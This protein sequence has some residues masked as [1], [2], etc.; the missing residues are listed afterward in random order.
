LRFLIILFLAAPLT[1]CAQINVNHF[2][3]NG[4]QAIMNNEYPRAIE[5]FNQVVSVRPDLFE[6]Y[7]LRAISKYNLGDYKGAEQDL[8]AAIQMKPNYPEALLYRGICRERMMNFSDAIS[9]FDRALKLEPYNAEI[10][11]R[12]AFTKSMMEEHSAA[13]EVCNQA[14]KIDKRNERAY[15]CRAWNRFKIYDVEGA[16]QDY[17]KALQFNQFSDDT[18]TKRGLVKAF[19]LNYSGAIEDFNEA[20]KIDSSNTHTWYQ[21]GRV[22]SELEKP[23]EALRCYEKMVELDP[24][25]ALGYSERGQIRNELGDTDGA[26]EDYTMVI[27]LTKG[28]LLTYFSR[29]SIYYELGKYSAAIEDFN[30]SIAIYPEFAEAY[31]NRALAYSRLGMH[32]KATTDREKATAIKAELYQLDESGQQK[33]LKKIQELATI[34]DDFQG[35]DTRYGR[36]QNQTITIKPMPDYVVIPETWVP[37]SLRQNTLLFTNLNSWPSTKLTTLAHAGWAPKNAQDK[38]DELNRQLALNPE[39]AETLFK[40]GV[41]FQLFGNYE[42]AQD[43]YSAALQ[44]DSEHNA[45]LLNLAVVRGKMLLLT[46]AF[47]HPLGGNPESVLTSSNHSENQQSIHAIIDKILQQNQTFVPA[48]YNLAN[49]LATGG[50][51]GESLQMMDEIINLRPELIAPHYNKALTLLYLSKNEDA[52]RHLSTAGE[53]GYKPAYATIKKYCQ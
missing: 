45:I 33:E 37:D 7:F 30:Q 38:L 47:E 34:K 46:E 23:H 52:C 2:I 14:L 26:I 31:F 25:S 22:Y 11:V 27:V 42:L 44:Y 43:A 5:L 35:S 39:D 3:F 48:M 41:I 8:S 32:G 21:L 51:Y 49:L 6:P 1:L 50:R 9:D 40:Q 15:L 19:K 29:G 13:I 20:L 53:L 12:K 17:D 4:K 18:Y 10:Y 36:I 24:Q 28:H 16:I